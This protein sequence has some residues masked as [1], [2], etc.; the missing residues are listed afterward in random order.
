MEFLESIEY[1]DPLFGIII[2]IF[3]IGLISLFAYYWNYII[4]KRQHQNLLKFMKNFDYIGFDK[5]IKEFLALNPNPTSSL[6]FMAKTY[7]KCADYEK[8]IRLYNTLLNS[9]KNPVDKIPILEDLGD[10]YYKAGFPLR[11][12][13]IYL[14]ILYHYPRSPKI[15]K[16]LIRIYEELTLYQDALNA[17]DCLE[18]IEGKTKM[19]HLYLQAKIIISNQNSTEIKPEKLEKLI[20]EEPKLLRLVLSFFKDFYPSYFWRFIQNKSKEEIFQILD[21]LWNLENNELPNVAFQNPILND[22]FQAKGY[23]PLQKGTKVSFELESLCLLRKYRSYQG[24]LQFNYSCNSCKAISP[25][26]FEICPHCGELLSAKILVF[27]KEKYDEES[28]SFL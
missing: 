10:V 23:Y 13:E 20:E 4:S 17:L 12:K 6:I 19:H 5:E 26:S 18:E 11:S 2:L 8:A 25:L 27:I 21:I 24:D 9:I 28:Y 1:R 16:S 7:Q 3:C 22:I 15:L 14:E